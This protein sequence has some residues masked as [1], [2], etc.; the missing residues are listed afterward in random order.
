MA[1]VMSLSAEAVRSKG[2][3]ESRPLRTLALAVLAG[4]LLPA[5]LSTCGRPAPAAPDEPRRRLENPEVGYRLI[6]PGDWLVRGGL[7]ATAFAQEGRCESVEIVDSLPPAEAGPG[8]A[9]R[10]SLVQVC[11]KQRR[12]GL[13]LGEFVRSRYA[14]VFGQFEEATLGGAPA[15]RAGREGSGQQFLL[16]TERH[17]L[18]VVTAVVADAGRTALRESQVEEVLASFRLGEVR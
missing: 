14:S 18:E 9:V 17:R 6:Y 12:D 7:V 8:A 15:Y 3:V 5:A 10:H 1:V 11:W 4:V 16:Q 2:A 13:D